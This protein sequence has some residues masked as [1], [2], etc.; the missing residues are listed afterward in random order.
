MSLSDELDKLLDVVKLDCNY[1][2][3]P[4]LLFHNI[5]QIDVPSSLPS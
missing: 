2:H 1:I 5:P 3:A 4:T